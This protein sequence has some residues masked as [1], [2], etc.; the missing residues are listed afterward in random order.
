MVDY[1]EKPSIADKEIWPALSC[2][3]RAIITKKPGSRRRLNGRTREVDPH[4]PTGDQYPRTS[5]D[6]GAGIGQPTERLRADHLPLHQRN[7]P[8]RVGRTKRPA[9]LP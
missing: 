5:G 4:Y 7:V 9:R 2:P 6:Q 3:V 8:D 1:M